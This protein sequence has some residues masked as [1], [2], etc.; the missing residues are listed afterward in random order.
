MVPP[1]LLN[2]VGVL[3]LEAALQH[4]NQDP[5]LFKSKAKDSFNAFDTA[6]KNTDKLRSKLSSQPVEEEKMEIDSRAQNPADKK[7]VANK[8]NALRITILFNTAFWYELDHQFNLS[9]IWYK[10][11][12]QEQPD[13]IDA[14]L[15]LAYL[16]KKRGDVNRSFH[17]I[18]EASK[19][20]AKAPVNQ[21]CM[22][23]KLFF[24]TGRTKDAKAEF[25]FILEKIVRD[26]SYS[27]LSLANIAFKEAINC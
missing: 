14:F 16:A 13:Y 2:N 18:D 3:R 8:Y 11:I 24:D 5:K 19:S 27:F 4:Q 22:K 21:H 17:W 15:R 20:R 7:D 1:E 9:N 26:D 25:V 23:G 12:I 10:K 6:L